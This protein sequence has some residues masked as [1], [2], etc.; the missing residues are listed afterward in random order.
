M[1]LVEETESEREEER[2]ELI[3]TICGVVVQLI[4]Y[5]ILAVILMHTIT[6]SV[7]SI[8]KPEESQTIDYVGTIEDMFIERDKAISKYVAVIDI[9]QHSYTTYIKQDDFL[10]YRIGDMVVVHGKNQNYS[11]V[12]KFNFGVN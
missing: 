3:Y 2:N 10:K 4:A 8:I 12:S 7:E 6:S 5:A 9:G 11:I 1:R